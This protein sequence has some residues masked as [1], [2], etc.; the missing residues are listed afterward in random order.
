MEIQLE[1]A[2]PHAILSYSDKSIHVAQHILSASCVI[3]KNTIH[4]DWPIHTLDALTSEHVDTLLK[5]KP[6]VILIG[7]AGKSPPIPW[8][9]AALSQKKIGI[10]YMSIG[11]A[12]RTFNVLLS[13]HRS[14]VLG[15][16]L[17]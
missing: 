6:T 15:I 1:S 7:H 8:L 4:T 11:A 5:D 3:S 12:C 17:A 9:T 10:E 2:E 13:E 14:V 16:I